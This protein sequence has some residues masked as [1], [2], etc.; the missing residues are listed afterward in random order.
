MDGTEPDET[1]DGEEATE[2]AE[3]EKPTEPLKDVKLKVSLVDITFN[4]PGQGYTF[5]VNG[6]KNNEVKWTSGDEKIVTV[7]ENGFV[8]SIGRGKTTIICQYGDQKVEI[9]INCKW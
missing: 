3:E 2:P 7:D 1:T 5:K 9:K 6:L 8:T 4:A